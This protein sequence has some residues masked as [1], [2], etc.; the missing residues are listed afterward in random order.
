MIDMFGTLL[1]IFAIII[2]GCLIKVLNIVSSRA[3]EGMENL[4]YWIL[5]PSLLIVKLGNVELKEFDFLPMATALSL[6]TIMT[7]IILIFLKVGFKIKQNSYTSVLQ[8][9]VRQN[10]YI[11]LADAGPLYG[12]GGE[13]LAAIGILA[14]IPLVNIISVLALMKIKNT[15]GL[16][17]IVAVKQLIKN[18]IIVACTLGMFANASGLGVPLFINETLEL[19]SRGALPLGLLAVGAGLSFGGLIR[20]PLLLL[21]SN[22]LKL[23]LMP[24]LTAWLCWCFDVDPVASGV[25]ILFAAL[26]TSASSYIMS[27]QFGGNHELMAAIL[28]SQV[29][30]AIATIPLVLLFLT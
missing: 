9:G 24:V 13:A 6:A 27:R 15:K 19:A 12:I 7:V 8:G 14:V 29:I 11:G 28:T 10:S 4:V 5:L 30:M 17:V 23:I 26:P 25:A 22:F 18:P 3:W 2:L 20:N 16:N 1:P 21:G